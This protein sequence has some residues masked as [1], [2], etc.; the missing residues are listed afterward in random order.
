[1]KA[2]HQ[3]ETDLRVICAPNPSPMTGEGT[4]SYILG[5]NQLVVIDPGPVDADHLSALRAAIGGLPVEAIL[6]THAH[7]DHSPLARQLSQ[8][9]SAPVLAFGDAFAGRSEQMARLAELGLSGGGEGV[10]TGFAPDRC[11]GD[12]ESLHL[13]GDEIRA[14]WTPGHFGNH[15]CF[16]WRGA[17]FSGDHVMAW[18][19]T[20]IS[21]PDGDI[22][23]YMRSLDRL[24]AEE[25]RVL[26]PGHGAAVH[27][28]ATRIL[29][30]RSHRL[31]REA[32]ILGALADGPQQIGGLVRIIYTDT[33]VAMH[34]AAARNVFAHLI[35][36]EARGLVVAE[37]ELGFEARYRLATG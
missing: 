23:A 5:R 24:D 26:Y 20:F 14:L 18:S 8:D 35:D 4:N 28:P 16:A 30:L 13:D 19:S 1:M 25:A 10:D 9:T 21:P 32:A 2:S 15:L 7:R 22:G 27:D 12:G 31:A 3:L 29:E 36:L 6:V 34:G 33:P 17:V 37:P 11:L